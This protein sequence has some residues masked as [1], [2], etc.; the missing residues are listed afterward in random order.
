MIDRYLKTRYVAGAR[1]PDEYDCWGMTRDARVELFGKPLLP[2]C[3][4]AKPGALKEI[5]AAC[6]D[7]SETYGLNPSPRATGAIATAWRG[8]LCVHVGLVVE[9]DGRQWILETDVGIGPCLTRPSKFEERYTRVIYY[10]D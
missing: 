8:K 2:S 6:G 5:T 7:V 9:A 10:A 3:P 1:G 4:A